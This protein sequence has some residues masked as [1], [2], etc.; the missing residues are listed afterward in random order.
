MTKSPTRKSGKASRKR[1]A[2]SRSSRKAAAA[3]K[4]SKPAAPK[5]SAYERRIARYLAA[6][7]G[8]TRQQAR[9]HKQREHITRRE[10]ER[11]R[12]EAYALR[13]AWRGEGRGARSAD[14]IEEDLLEKIAEHG[15]GWFS[16]L[17]RAINALH[18]RYRQGGSAPLGFDLGEIAD[19]YD[20]PDGEA[21]YH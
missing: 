4:R 1:S 12:V 6:H 14:E 13:Q 7:P 16:R 21:F 15:F 11:E 10:R 2:P 8:A 5:L 9:G 3:P 17:E 19:E 18:E 20:I